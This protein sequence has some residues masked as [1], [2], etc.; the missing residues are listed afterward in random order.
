MKLKHSAL[1]IFYK[2]PLLR[3]YFAYL[4]MAYIRQFLV[5]NELNNLNILKDSQDSMS[6][7]TQSPAFLNGVF[8]SR[9]ESQG[10]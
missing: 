8:L 5:Y 6:L 2:I 3:D 10:W 4:S 7:P 9:Q 1:Q